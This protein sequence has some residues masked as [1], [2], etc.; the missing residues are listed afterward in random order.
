[1][2]RFV[3]GRLCWLCPLPLSLIDPGANGGLPSLCSPVSSLSC[4]IDAFCFD[5]LL[6]LLL[7]LLLFRLNLRNGP[8]PELLLRMDRCDI[9]CWTDQTVNPWIGPVPCS[10]ELFCSAQFFAV[11]CRTSLKTLV[12]MS[13]GRS[14]TG[15]QSNPIQ[16]Q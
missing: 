12:Q 4:S 1:M 6:L 9:W 14:Q 16:Q 7:L 2:E 8:P 15:I 10:T 5:L 13:I 3:R 11:P